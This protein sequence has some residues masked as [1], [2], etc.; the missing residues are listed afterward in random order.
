MDDLPLLGVIAH[1]PLVGYVVHPSI[2]HPSTYFHSASHQYIHSAN[3]VIR[4]ARRLPARKRH[5]QFGRL[6]AHCTRP[7]IDRHAI[8]PRGH[9]HDGAG[10]HRRQSA[11]AAHHEPRA[12]SLHFGASGA[13]LRAIPSCIQFSPLHW[14]SPL[15]SPIPHSEQ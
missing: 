9:G 15:L 4:V 12:T 6:V 5:S 3:A 10:R 11:A 14:T 2:L 13:Q 8:G 7:P 1:F